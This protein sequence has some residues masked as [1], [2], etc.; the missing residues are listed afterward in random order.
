MINYSQLETQHIFEERTFTTMFS[1]N[2]LRIIAVLTFIFSLTF[3]TLAQDI[4]SSAVAPK[5]V[6]VALNDDDNRLILNQNETTAIQFK[7]RLFNGKQ[8]MTVKWEVLG[9]IDPALSITT[10]GSSTDVLK[11]TIRGSR[12]DFYG[13]PLQATLTMKSGKKIKLGAN[14][15]IE[16]RTPPTNEDFKIKLDSSSLT[17]APGTSQTVSVMVESLNGFSSSVVLSTNGKEGLD[18]RFRDQLILP[19]TSTDLTITASSNISEGSTTVQ[20][21]GTSGITSRTTLL[22]IQIKKPTTVPTPVI[23]RVGRDE[24]NRKRLPDASLGLY[25]FKFTAKNFI[26]GRH[27]W[28]LSKDGSYY[29]H[30]F[31]QDPKIN[32][33]TGEFT[34]NITDVG[35]AEI[36]IHITDNQTSPP[37]LSQDSTSFEFVSVLK[38][39]QQFPV[40]IS[41]T[42]IRD[43]D[44]LTI[45]WTAPNP[46]GR[47]L[48]L[49]M[50]EDCEHPE[51]ALIQ[52]PAITVLANGGNSVRLQIK[53]PLLCLE[54]NRLRYRIRVNVTD[55]TT[56]VASLAVPD[57][58]PAV[59]GAYQGTS[60]LF[61]IVPRN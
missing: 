9:V 43:G 22:Q 51:R 8:P 41:S 5:G 50:N 18:F 48:I 42:K 10:D 44:E 36:T 61:E 21:T 55:P 54:C 26:P 34:A 52:Q 12:I 2:Y 31:A 7:A 28:F 13:L 24:C 6:I 33:D 23:D 20:I 35:F 4:H 29:S 17:L 30:P 58:E 3:T 1:T 45:T 56:P 38:P 25:T 27:K 40:N 57:I 49:L 15:T 47:T 59:N 46:N 60:E 16:V 37:N 53:A 39:L 11:A 19:N 14:F 32:P